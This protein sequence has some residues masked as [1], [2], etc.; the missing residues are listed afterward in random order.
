MKYD[1]SNPV[2]MY[3]YGAMGGTL[4]P[5]YDATLGKLWLEHGGVYVIT[6]IRGSTSAERRGTSLAWIGSTPMRIPSQSRRTW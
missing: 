4:V 2:L 3:G 1:G 5:H 6:S